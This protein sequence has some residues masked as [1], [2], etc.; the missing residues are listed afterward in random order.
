MSG[1]HRNRVI[2]ILLSFSGWIILFKASSQ[3]NSYTRTIKNDSTSIKYSP[4]IFTSGF[5]DVMNNGQVNASARF[6]RLSIGEPGKFSIPLSLY[7]GVSNNTFQG[8]QATATSQRSNDQLINQYINP[9]SG[10]INISI[11][12]V[13]YFSNTQRVTKAGFLYQ[14]GERVL[15]G[16][17]NGAIG[18]PQTG[19]PSNFLNS[20][21]TAGFYFQTGA[22]ER[23][24]AKNVG[25]FWI[26]CRY[27]AC[28]S[29][30][31]QIKEFLPDIKTN[32]LYHGYS[33]GFGVEINN[34]VNIKAIF[35]RYVK[36]PELE[37]YL[38]I[39]QFTFNYSLK[40]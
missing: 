4:E 36:K 1:S 25:I 15:T 27:I 2:A 30:P 21:T 40:S 20:F 13:I 23:N 11:D 9:L 32:G 34:L 6:I 37:Y 3:I 39:Y 26:A 19:K 16:Y 8:Q 35:Y 22:W 38:P 29:S 14:F 31:G 18:N 12:G 7:G 33:L 5:I 10:L 17:R 24:N 28:Y